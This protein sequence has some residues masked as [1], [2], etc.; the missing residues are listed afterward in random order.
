MT[1]THARRLEID[2]LRALIAVQ[3]HGG[4]TRAATA[5]GLTQS[6]VSHKIKRLEISLDA[7]LLSRRPNAPLFTPAGMDLLGYARRILGIHDEAVLSL[8]KSPLSGKIALGMT[9]DTACT[10][11]ARILGRFRRLHPEVSVRVQVD[12]SIRLQAEM[13]AGALDL[14]V[15]QIFRHDLRPTDTLLFEDRLHWVKAPDLP[16]TPGR[17]IP[18][19]SFSED[20]FYR[21]WALE[22]GQDGGEI[23]ETVL[24]CFSTAGI[25]TGVVSGLGVALLSGRHL[26]PDMQ[27]ID[28]LFPPPPDVAY[29]IRPARKGRN[30]AVDALIKEIRDD[31][32]TIGRLR[33]A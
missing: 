14:A 6:A 3:D 26:R 22:M 32:S 20:C 19:L 24:D 10:D 17:P 2:A 28:H 7:E 9:E 25:V 12:M 13:A 1:H 30:P 16:L 11:L 5:L 4:V 31:I 18:F 21:R 15:L 23:F 27:V 33:V 29:A 8:S